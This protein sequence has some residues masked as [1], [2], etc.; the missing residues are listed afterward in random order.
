MGLGRPR[1]S[2]VMEDYFG[3]AGSIAGTATAEQRGA[4]MRRHRSAALAILNINEDLDAKEV[5]ELKRKQFRQSSY[6]ALK[7]YN[8]MRLQMTGKGI[9]NVMVS[10]DNYEGLNNC[11]SW[12]SDHICS[13]QG[14]DMM[15]VRQ[16]LRSSIGLCNV[17]AD[18]D[19]SHA[20]DNDFDLADKE[21]KQWGMKRLLRI[22]RNA[23][24]GPWDERRRFHQLKD[25]IKEIK[26]FVDPLAC[27]IWL[28]A[29]PNILGE[30]NQHSRYSESD[31]ETTLFHEVFNPVDGYL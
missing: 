14:S 1:P 21:T 31:I 24:H 29:V 3:E 28:D 8:N 26:K 6:L 2:Q 15:V 20:I 13:D 16:F 7:A 30:L 18:D 9:T 22:A 17:D 11:M 10:R 19:I 27:P 25:V 5:V 12:R 4:C 23:V